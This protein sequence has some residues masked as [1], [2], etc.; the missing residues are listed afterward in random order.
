MN[1][2]NIMI[3][4]DFSGEYRIFPRAR[5]CD[6]APVFCRGN[7]KMLGRPVGRSFGVVLR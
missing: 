1:G 6:K 7:D 2:Y 3:Y 4:N 5:E